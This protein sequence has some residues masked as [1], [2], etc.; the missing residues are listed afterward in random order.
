MANYMLIEVEAREVKQNGKLNLI[1][2]VTWIGLQKGNESQATLSVYSRVSPFK[3]VTL[4]L[5][6]IPAGHPYPFLK[7]LIIPL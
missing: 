1:K 6:N 2:P 4:L 7:A 3:E 5:E